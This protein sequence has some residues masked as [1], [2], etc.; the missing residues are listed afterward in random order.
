MPEYQLQLDPRNPGQFFACCGLFELSEL[1]EPGGE[2]WF[3]EKGREFVLCTNAP[4]P[5]QNLGLLPQQDK[6]DDATL[7]PLVLAVGDRTLTL[8]WWLNETLTAKSRFK[9]W[10]GQQTPRRVLGELL[11]LLDSSVAFACLPEF[12][13][14]TKTRFGIDARS[15]WEALDTGYSPN[16]LGQNAATFPWIEVL[17]V[18]GLQGFRPAEDGRARYRYSTW[19][20]PLPL[21]TARVACAAPWAGL[22]SQSFVFEVAVRGQGYKTFLFAQGVDDV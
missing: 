4:I 14:Y 20:A 19:L 5:P 16:D 11:R 21:S 1:V 18:A 8:N 13:V 6:P 17:A 3:R 22:P 2:A 15:A 12:F 9:T 10:G 7:E